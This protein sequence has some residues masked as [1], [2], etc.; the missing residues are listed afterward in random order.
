MLIIWLCHISLS[1][2]YSILN[3]SYFPSHFLYH[4][5]YLHVVLKCYTVGRM[6]CMNITCNFVVAS[7]LVPPPPPNQNIATAR[8][9]Y[10]SVLFGFRK[11]FV[12]FFIWPLHKHKSN[13][14]LRIKFIRIRKVVH[15]KR[16]FALA[17]LSAKNYKT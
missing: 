1:H 2:A 14:L 6:F 15:D 5:K 16:T 10:I 13:P 11:P 3:T 4:R 8:G 9:K 12:S 17:G 7:M